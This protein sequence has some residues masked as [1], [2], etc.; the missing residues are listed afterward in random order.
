MLTGVY[1]FIRLLRDPTVSQFLTSLLP[2]IPSLRLYYLSDFHML[3]ALS[4][5]ELDVILGKLT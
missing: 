4:F 3:G 1:T 2:F 5:Q